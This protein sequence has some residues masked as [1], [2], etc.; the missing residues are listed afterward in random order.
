MNSYSKDF[1]VFDK[2]TKT[3]RGI[4]IFARK[5]RKI[6][7]TKSGIIQEGYS[8][9]NLPFK[10]V[11]NKMVKRTDNNKNINKFFEF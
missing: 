9:D 3:G 1:Q 5:D 10:V 11:K 6:E 7:I 4:W 2:T 8:A